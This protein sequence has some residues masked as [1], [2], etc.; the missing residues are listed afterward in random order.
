LKIFKEYAKKQSNSARPTTSYRRKKIEKEDL[1]DD[2][3]EY[4]DP[5]T[6]LYL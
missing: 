4:E 2:I 6:K 3:D 1:P 5:T